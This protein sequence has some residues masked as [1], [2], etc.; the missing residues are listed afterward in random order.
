MEYPIIKFINS[1]FGVL[2]LQKTDMILDI[3]N[4]IMVK[5]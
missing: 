2:W 5:N 4:N 3:I 1:L